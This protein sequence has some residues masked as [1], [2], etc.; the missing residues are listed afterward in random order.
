MSNKTDEQLTSVTPI[1]TNA[2]GSP[3]FLLVGQFA[4]TTNGKTKVRQLAVSLDDFTEEEAVKAFKVME[5]A[6]KKLSE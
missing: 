5:E 1:L 4:V 6:Q 2:D 3:A